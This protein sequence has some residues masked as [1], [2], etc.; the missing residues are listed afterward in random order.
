VHQFRSLTSLIQV[1][2]VWRGVLS[3]GLPPLAI[4]VNDVHVQFGHG[5]PQHC[6]CGT[7]AHEPAFMR[8]SSGNK[9]GKPAVFSVW[10]STIKK[11]TKKTGIIR[12]IVSPKSG[13]QYPE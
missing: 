2:A 4:E 1:N 6:G 9:G 13:H 12:A 3:V 5:L 8:S 10:N 7:D 11:T